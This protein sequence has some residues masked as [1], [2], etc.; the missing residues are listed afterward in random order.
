MTTSLPLSTPSI[1]LSYP[2]QFLSSINVTV[3]PVKRI[4]VK[5]LTQD[6]AIRGLVFFTQQALTMALT[7]TL[8]VLLS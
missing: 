7:D 3:S 5:S 1:T 4:I 6:S 8:S 2:Y